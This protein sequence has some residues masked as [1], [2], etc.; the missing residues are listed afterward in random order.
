M[1]RDSKSGMNKSVLYRGFVHIYRRNP[2]W[3][4]SF[5]CNDSFKYAHFGAMIP[6]NMHI[7]F[8]N[9]SGRLLLKLIWNE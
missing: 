5:W 1:N 4:T 3:K 2:K 7:V 9:E 6:L 8:K